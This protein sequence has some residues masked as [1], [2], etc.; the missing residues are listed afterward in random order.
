MRLRGPS[1]RV[2]SGDAAVRQPLLL[3]EFQLVVSR[4]APWH[5][6][7]HLLRGSL[8]SSL[9]RTALAAGAVGGADPVSAR[10][11]QV[12]VDLVLPISP[13]GRPRIGSGFRSLRG[14]VGSARLVVLHLSMPRL[15]VRRA[16]R[17]L[18]AR[19]RSRRVRPFRCLLSATPG[20][21]DRALAGPVRTA[22]RGA[23][24]HA[25][26]GVG[27][28]AASGLWIVP[29]A[30]ARRL[31]RSL[32]GQRLHGPFRQFV[33]RS[34]SRT[35][36]IHDTALWGFLWLLAHRPWQRP[37]LRHTAD[38][39]FPAASPLPDHRG[40]LAA[41]AH[42]VDAMDWRLSLSTPGAGDGPDR[43]ILPNRAGGSGSP[44][45]LGHFGFVA[46]RQLDLPR[47]RAVPG[48]HVAHPRIVATESSGQRFGDGCRG[49]VVCSGCQD[50]AIW[51]WS[52]WLPWDR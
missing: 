45:H 13:T 20:R 40:I 11:L 1:S 52:R 50:L 25:R 22:G 33:S 48:R 34:A 8:S 35:L 4:S 2:A 32:C 30:R 24:T 46:R 28:V 19:T 41:V 5:D 29:Q 14:C 26:H 7:R 49:I 21:T 18:R 51:S 31:V 44:C 27:G 47:V 17:L 6:S 36:R 39:Q 12:P 43:E 15:R 3:R 10:V 37:A 16:A 38:R 9:P 42:L 23:P